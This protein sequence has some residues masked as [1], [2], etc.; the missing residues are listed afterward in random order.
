M[1]YSFLCK[2]DVII[3]K[4]SFSNDT[5]TN[6]QVKFNEFQRDVPILMPPRKDIIYHSLIDFTEPLFP[7]ICCTNV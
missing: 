1:T 2:N 6:G 3:L 4:Q 5:L 7:I